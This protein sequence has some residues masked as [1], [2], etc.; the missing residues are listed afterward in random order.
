MGGQAGGPRTHVMKV[1]WRVRRDRVSLVWPFLRLLHP[2][3]VLLTLV[4]CVAFAFAIRPQSSPTT[5]IFILLVL[6]FN[7][8]GISLF[9]DVCD[10]DIDA[11]FQ[12]DSALVKGAVSLGLVETVALA[13]S[14]LAVI[15]AASQGWLSLVL[16]LIGTLAGILYSS[17]FK[18]TRWSWL[19]FA[20][21]FP[22]LLA[23]EI[24]ILQPSVPNL[25]L[26]WVVGVPAAIAV[27]LADSIPDLDHDESF[28]S[29]GLAI[30]L[31]RDRARLVSLLLFVI[32]AVLAIGLSPLS[33]FPL[34]AIVGGCL[35]LLVVVLGTWR[36][37]SDQEPRYAI[38]AGAVLVGLGWT[39]ALVH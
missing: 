4:A 25:W 18:R 28:G 5:I 39:V 33:R 13:L 2:L 14:W 26:I 6:I 31:G 3:P 38:P 9:N 29:F 17:V 1:D 36:N 20:I 24:E 7:Q 30:H 37:R 12:R 22:L 23:W 19:P 8:V 16:V 27:H 21:A 15:L 11:T 34:A 10:A 32:S 35:A